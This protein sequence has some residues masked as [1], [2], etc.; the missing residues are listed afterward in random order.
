MAEIT[1]AA[2]QDGFFATDPFLGKRK[3]N[4][5]GSQCFAVMKLD[6]FAEFDFKRC[7]TDPL[8]RRCQRRFKIRPAFLIRI[9]KIPANKRIERR[10][11]HTHINVAR[12]FNRL[13]RSR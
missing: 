12:L 5:I 8:P 2:F 11:M 9:D 10:V 3:D 13:K 1:P 7:R 6:P 4:I